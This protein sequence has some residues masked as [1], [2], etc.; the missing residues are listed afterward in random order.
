VK[1]LILLLIVVLLI[2]PFVK[3][4]DFLGY[5]NSNYSGVT[6]I[7]LNPAAVVDSRYKADISLIGFSFST[8][9]NYLGLKRSALDHTGGIRG[10][11]P[12][13]QDPNFIKNCFEVKNSTKDKSLY[14]ANQLYLPSFLITISKRNAIALKAKARTLINIDGV[15]EELA[16]LIHSE[17]NYPSLWVSQLHNKNLSIQSMAWAEYGLT[18]GHVFTNEGP[19]FLK[20]AATVKYLKGAGATYLHIKDLDYQFT[21]DTSLSLFHLDVDYGYSDFS[22]FQKNRSIASLLSGSKPSFGFDLGVVYE[23]RP[24]YEKFKYDMDGK[25]DLYRKDKNKYKLRVGISVVD[26]GYVKF[27]KGEY[28]RSLAIDFRALD[29]NEFD[30]VKN[31]QDVDSIVQAK[32]TL[33]DKGEYFKMNL[34]TAFSLQIDYNIWKD[35]YV[36]FTPY[37]SPQLKNN[38]EKVHDIT[39]FSLTPRWDNKWLGVFV[40]FSY[41]GMGNKKIGLALRMGPIIVGTNSFG[42]FVT[43]KNIYGADV[44]FMLKVPILYGRPKDRDHDKVSNGKDKCKDVPGTWEFLGCPD[45]DLDHI[46][47]DKDACPDEAGPAE[48]NGCP[49]TDGDKIID[50]K[51]DCPNEAGIPEF[52]GCPDTDGDKIIDSEDNCP[53]EAGLAK[54]KGCPDKD[55]DGIMDKEDRCPNE[56]GLPKFKGCPERNDDK[57]ISPVIKSI[58]SAI[59]KPIETM[60]PVEPPKPVAVE[61]IVEPVKPIVPPEKPS[62]IKQEVQKVNKVKLNKTEAAV[63][64]KAFN[65]LEFAVG[66][67]EIKKESFESLDELAA[68]MMKKPNWKL[69]I[70]GHTDNQG[71]PVV[72][73]KLSEKR[74]KA[75]RLYLISKGVASDRFKVEWFGSKKPIADNKTAAGRQKNRR[76]EML[77]FE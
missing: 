52:N 19:H 57:I 1:K 70:A 63:L 25:T 73:L 21:S 32:F 29:L 18:F 39:T 35:F 31:A 34:P 64:K 72:N 11:Y 3:A 76:V 77:I 23:W 4:Q 59:E 51:D 68:L 47:D 16:T 45:K 24:D 67:D 10:N 13:F 36:N 48:F 54:F 33:R 46:P 58:E 53:T 42:I 15:G 69:S 62:G 50:K 6:G 8:Y 74:A 14:Q 55:N 28:S 9:N 17:L 27:K 38:N 65:N 71:N 2:S 26:I 61:P 12:A 5:I 7:D 56:A 30:E 44:Y 66:K 20:T 60:K 49:D 37:W 41:D 22:S 40:P 43:K 75:V